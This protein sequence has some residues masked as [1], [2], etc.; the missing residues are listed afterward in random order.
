[1][2]IGEDSETSHEVGPGT[3]ATNIAARLQQLIGGW[4]GVE[5]GDNIQVLH[6]ECVAAAD[7]GGRFL[8]PVSL[9]FVRDLD[10]S[11]LATALQRASGPVR[12]TTPVFRARVAGR[13]DS[14]LVPFGV[15]GERPDRWVLAFDDELSLSDQ[16]ACYGHAVG[17]LLLNREFRRMGSLPPLD[18]RDGYTHVDWLAE[19]R[20]LESTRQAIDRRVIE[21]YPLLTALLRVEDDLAT[22]TVS[23][24]L[25]QLLAAAGWRGRSITAPYVFTSGRVYLTGNVT[26]RGTRLR[27]DALLRAEPS[28][29][30]AAVQVI[31]PGQTRDDAER[32]LVEFVRDRLALPF[33]Y[34]IDADGQ[35]EEFDWSNTS[36]AQRQ[37]R[38][39]LPGRDELLNRWTGAL[40]LGNPQENQTLLYPFQGGGQSLRYYQ[41]AAINRS[42]IAV[43]QAREGRRAPRI[44]LNLATGTG[45]TR[46]S[47]QT[48]W[49]LKRAGTIRNVLFLTDRDYLL[50][51]AM[52]NEFAPFG[53][54]RER[55]QGE[56]R[57]ARDV[58]FA[59]YQALADAEGR[60]GIY[61]D[62]PRNFFDLVIVDECHRGSAQDESSW[63]HILE[64]FSSAVQIGLTATPRR[65]DNVQTY[66][67][68]GESL[69]TYSLRAGIND[70]FLA[71]YR[72]VRVL[73]GAESETDG[74][75]DQ[76]GQTESSDNLRSAADTLESSN[77]LRA[78]TDVIA[79]HLAAFLHRT[80][81]MAKTIVFCVDQ[82]HA[83]QMKLALERACPEQV[84]RYP[85]YVERIVAEEG[86][87]GRRALGRFSTPD[88]RT[89]VLV[90]TSRLLST[91]VDVP[92]CKNIVLARPI[93]SIV[94]FK[95]IIGRGTRLYEPEKTWF[96]IL[97]YSGATRMF[98]DPDFDGDPEVVEVEPLIPEELQS[99]S[100]NETGPEELKGTEVP[101]PLADESGITTSTHGSTPPINIVD[102]TGEPTST[103]VVSSGTETTGGP[104][105]S[106]ALQEGTGAYRTNQETPG[107]Q[108]ASESAEPSAKTGPHAGQ[109]REA[110]PTVASGDRPKAVAFPATTAKR[111]TIT[112]ERSL[113]N[114]KIIRVIGEIVYE[115]GPDGVTLRELS[116]RDFAR[117]AL[118]GLAATPDDLRA[119]WLRPEARQEIRDRLV[120]QGVDLQLLAVALDE[121]GADPLNL[122]VQV[123][124]GEPSLTRSARVANLRTRF[125]WFFA[126]FAPSARE[127][128]DAILDKYSNGE[129]DVINNT[130]LLKV[131]PL[132]NQGT[133]VE[134]A[135]RFG[136]GG[137]L[138]AA[139]EEM[140]K[141]LYA[142]ESSST[143]VTS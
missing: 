16:V 15:A 73:M 45:K 38:A 92:T 98:F 71:P 76:L 51:Q 123:A 118:R 96:T 127:V 13:F 104:T 53:D 122:L 22:T 33:G 88:E 55:I 56:S 18:P 105:Q 125:P 136:S 3:S 12:R 74:A 110:T 70:G 143:T 83:E 6:N 26:R 19:L 36:T 129:T 52:D 85:D 48:V 64:Y 47:F 107:V 37:K 20:Q 46:I 28:V 134:L 32:R 63:R 126:R 142:D 75:A 77:A 7:L 131:P 21:A 108:P 106:R 95:Q 103:A 42:I 1:M 82:A 62:Y 31:R 78:R 133:F 57:T 24:D 121:P 43:L 100:A 34:L 39:N 94:E 60:P 61:R 65:R 130:E 111:S 97:D 90:T 84:A 128:L 139:L 86:H 41:V 138:R 68:F 91:G 141:L 135:K 116:Y 81:P 69:Y 80:D 58:L 113:P 8:V 117:E 119:R 29:P 102:G 5:R 40:G 54:A 87:E 124:F 115:L 120:E 44:L 17:H 67:Y 11:T 132:S 112:V 30:I 93:N 109:E 35:I 99:G 9:V 72:V 23:E 137:N 50:G 49:K 66:E 14:A 89:P 2:T 114:G 140:Q 10:A 79:K 27:V 4:R 25:R 59:T 101:P